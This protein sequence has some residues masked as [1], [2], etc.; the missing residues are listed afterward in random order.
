MSRSPTRTPD[1]SGTDPLLSNG[2]SFLLNFTVNSRKN[3][4]WK[5]YHGHHSEHVP[6]WE[7]RVKAPFLE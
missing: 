2:F 3:Y 5:S 4:L 1:T 6:A 7:H